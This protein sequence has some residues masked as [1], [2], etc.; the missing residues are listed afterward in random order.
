MFEGGRPSHSRGQGI[1]TPELLQEAEDRSV[2]V[3]SAVIVSLVLHN[4]LANPWG[5]EEGGNADTQTLEVEGDV[6]SIMGYLGVGEVVT[7]RYVDWRWNVVGETSVLV[8]GQDEESVLP[9]WRVANRLVNALDEALTEGNWGWRVV[10]LVAAALWV[11]I[12]ELGKRSSLGIG[13]KLVERSNVGLG[14]TRFERPLVESSV[15]VESQSWA[16]GGVLVV[17]PRDVSLGQLLEDAAL[18]ETVD[19]KGSIVGSMAVRGT[20]CEVCT[21]GVGRARDRRKPAIE[22][23]EILGHGTKHGNLARGIVVDDLSCARFV[24]GL[25][26]NG[27]LSDEATHVFVL[28]AHVNNFLIGVE[29]AED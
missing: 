11:D 7:S 23:D 27:L 25:V 3:L 17:H 29:G 15:W 13:I 12:C 21:V 24:E 28:D 8:K 5:D 19:P 14:S 16:S 20:G 10:R 1:Q 26:G 9:L 2:A 4:T 18:R 22:E 6:L